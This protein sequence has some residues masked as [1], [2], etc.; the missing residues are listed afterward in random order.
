[1]E[2][3]DVKVFFKTYDLQKK[4]DESTQL[5]FYFKGNEH[6]SQEYKNKIIKQ[7]P[8]DRLDNVTQVLN[9]KIDFSQY[10][11]V[12][13]ASQI[14]EI[15]YRRVGSWMKKTIP[16]FYEDKCLKRKLKK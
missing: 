6:I 15:D 8:K 1:M 14:L 2:T 16:E 9:S 7:C 13:H 11:W 12:K 4:Q 3:K 5:S 10:G